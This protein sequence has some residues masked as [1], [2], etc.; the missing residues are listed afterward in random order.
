MTVDRLR[1]GPYKPPAL[2]KGDRAFC[3]Y[4]DANVV[5]TSWTDT[6]SSA[7]PVATEARDVAAQSA[8]PSA[9]HSEMIR[10][11]EWRPAWFEFTHVYLWQTGT[12]LVVFLTFALWLR[13]LAARP[14]PA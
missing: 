1:F 3:L 10:I 13:T 9:L 6:N 12:I 4:R 11:L 8:A 5:V 2:K 14:Q 7:H